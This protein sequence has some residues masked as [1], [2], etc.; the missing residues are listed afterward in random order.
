LLSDGRR[1]VPGD[2][3][4][5][6]AGFQGK[7][8][9]VLT[10]TMEGYETLGTIAVGAS[11][12]PGDWVVKPRDVQ[13]QWSIDGSNWSHWQSMDLA[14]PPTDLYA[15]SRRLRY[16]LTAHKAKSV[17]YVRLRFINSPR[18]PIWHPNAG[19]PAWLMVDEVGIAR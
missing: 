6:W 1:A 5:G 7:D 16:T 12:S 17:H 18:L 8:T 19:Q 14:N 2:W 13:V 3:R 11:H 15:D 9:V 4:H 10:L